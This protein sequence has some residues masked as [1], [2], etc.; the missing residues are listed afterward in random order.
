M[1]APGDTYRVTGEEVNL[2]AGPSEDANVRTR[3]KAGDELIEVRREGAWL[4]VRIVSTGEEGWIYE[5][6]VKRLS[7]STLQE[8]AAAGPLKDLSGTFDTLLSKVSDYLGYSMVEKV[9]RVEPNTLR[10]TPTRE[11][12]LNGGGD[13]H[14]MAA[15][16]FYQM[17]KNHQNGR[18]VSLVML[19]DRGKD[20]V[21][22]TDKETGPALS[23]SKPER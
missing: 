10:V 20:Y 2:R 7:Q 3:V 19:D 18:P 5:G 4:G 1:A 9:E 8:G 15:M 16:A 21:T 13:G 14:V 12:L 17:W 6:L 22:I 23:I 11:W